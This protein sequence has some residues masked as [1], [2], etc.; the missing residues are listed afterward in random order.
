VRTIPYLQSWLQR[1]GPDG[2]E[3]VGIEAPEFDFEKVKSNVE[4]ADTKL[5]VTWPVALDNNLGVWNAFQTQYWP[6]KDIADRQG[7]LRYQDIGEGQYA[8][9][10]DVIRQLLG[11]PANSPR[12]AAP[13]TSGN[14]SGTGDIT[15]E[16]YLGTDEGLEGARSGTYTY[17]NPTNVG[18]DLVR[19]GGT[20]N[21]YSQE[22]T[23]GST[24]EIV[25]NY[26]ASQVN[27]VLAPPGPPNGGAAS[28]SAQLKVELDGAPVPTADRGQDIK[29]APDGSTYVDVTTDDMYRLILSP[30]LEAFDF[31]FGG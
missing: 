24:A 10:E 8:Q 3:I 20:W 28:G 14:A 26:H 12:A 19:L 27:L 21:G 7:N 23:A 17:P 6:T 11:V 22:I 2:L 29:L 31:T 13:N 30:G 4:T 25:L 15:D 18:D 1:Y 5:G 9:T 16:S